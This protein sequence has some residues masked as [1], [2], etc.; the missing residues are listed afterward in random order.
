M[1]KVKI[2]YHREDGIWWAESDDVPDF[3]AAADTFHD[4]RKL[5]LDGIDFT[6]DGAPT[7]ITEQMEDGSLIPSIVDETVKLDFI[8][9]RLPRIDQMTAN[10]ESSVLHNQFVSRLL[11]GASA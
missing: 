11:T 5:A 1:K 10:T 2:I 6:L 8:N 3:S 7:S 9:D 4:I